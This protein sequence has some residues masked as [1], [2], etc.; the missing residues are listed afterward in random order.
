M[1]S[2]YNFLRSKSGV[3]GCLR[4]VEERNENMKKSNKY[5]ERD[6]D[7]WREIEGN[8]FKNVF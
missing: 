6:W 2:F 7:Y 5:R 1:S 4:K 3:V 8:V